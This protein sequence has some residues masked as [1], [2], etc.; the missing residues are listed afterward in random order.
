MNLDGLYTETTVEWNSSFTV[1]TLNL[2]GV[3]ERGKALER[4]VR[5]LNVMRERIGL[6]SFAKVTS[7]NTFPMGVGIASS[8]ASFAALT[9]AGV[10]A[11]QINL[12]EQ[13]LTTIARLGSGS[14]SRSVPTGFVEWH[15]G[16]SHA[17]SFAES[18]AKPEYWNLVDVVAVVSATHK[19]IGSEDGHKTA[20]TSDLQAGRVAGANERLKQ[21]KQALLSRNFSQFAEVVELDSNLMHAVM[22]TSRPALFYWMPHTLTVM[23]K[24]REWREQGL[25]VC[26]TLDAGPNVHCICEKKDAEEVARLLKQMDGILDVRFAVAGGGASILS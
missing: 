2:N 15:E 4:V 26:Y 21:C 24:V 12:K 8:A 23:A 16:D 18:I 1:D 13:E 7:H 11:A 9:V 14:A 3:D 10:V 17:T 19:K 20:T 5:H 25:S 22:M 6:K